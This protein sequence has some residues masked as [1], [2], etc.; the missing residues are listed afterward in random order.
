MKTLALLT[1]SLSLIAGGQAIAQTMVQRLG[2]VCETSPAYRAPTA[3]ED[4]DYNPI[5]RTCKGDD[6]DVSEVLV[7]DPNNPAHLMP[8]SYLRLRRAR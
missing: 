8:E 1:L 5:I 4:C 2:E 7:R 3:N 6:C